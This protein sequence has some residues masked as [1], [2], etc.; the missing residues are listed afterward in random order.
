MGVCRSTEGE[1]GGSDSKLK[2]IA[3]I[4]SADKLHHIKSSDYFQTNVEGLKMKTDPYSLCLSS[5]C[6]LK[7]RFWSCSYFFFQSDLLTGEGSSQ[8]PDGNVTVLQKARP[9]GTSPLAPHSTRVTFTSFP[10][11][12]PPHPSSHLPVAKISDT[13]KERSLDCKDVCS[14]LVYLFPF[15]C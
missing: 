8:I 4:Q 5:E 13:L 11:K 9:L 14:S 15:T 3:S 2:S 12:C 6:I 7:P 10:S 1:A